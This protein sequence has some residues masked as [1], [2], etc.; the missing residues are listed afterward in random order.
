[1][2]G[3]SPSAQSQ[4]LFRASSHRR[5]GASAL[6]AR[7]TTS[8]ITRSPRPARL[9]SPGLGE[10]E[11]R[12]RSPSPRPLRSPSHGHAET[13]LPRW[14][15]RRHPKARRG[16]PP[17]QWTCRAGLLRPP[18]AGR[19][20]WRGGRR[21]THLHPEDRPTSGGDERGVRSGRSSTIPRSARVCSSCPATPDKAFEDAPPP[22]PSIR[23][24]KSVGSWVGGVTPACET[25][26]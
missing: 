2:A 3:F 9:E 20:F 25:I 24:L 21:R 17:P 18:P 15:R 6:Q 1:M 13:S 11:A 19:Q 14:R 7:S 8:P 23:R 12:P 5:S 4:E 16:W 22:L 26:D 10:A